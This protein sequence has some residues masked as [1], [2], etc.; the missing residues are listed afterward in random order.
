MKHTAIILIDV[1][2][3]PHCDNLV[4]EKYITVP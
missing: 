4:I 2:S 3:F 1:D